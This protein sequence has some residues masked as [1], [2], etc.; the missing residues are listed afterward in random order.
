MIFRVERPYKHYSDMQYMQYMQY[1]PPVVNPI[2]SIEADCYT[3]TNGVLELFK[4]KT[5][6]ATYSVG[7]WVSVIKE[8]DN[9]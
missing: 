2:D 1:R 8:K 3:V 4:N 9:K 7:N 6:V 5:P